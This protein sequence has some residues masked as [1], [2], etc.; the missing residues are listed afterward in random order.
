[1]KTLYAGWVLAGALCAVSSEADEANLKT[2]DLSQDI[3]RH[4][5][6][7]EGTL[8]V[9][10]GHPTTVSLPGRADGV[11]RVVREPRRRGRTDGAQRRR[12]QDV[13]AAG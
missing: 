3:G 13:D 8:D 6:I 9:Y 1:M 11:L 7:A 2:V 10:Q 12:R 5:V 4:V